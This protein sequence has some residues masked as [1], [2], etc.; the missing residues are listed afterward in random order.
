MKQKIILNLAMSLDGFIAD[1]DGK[2][3]WIVGDGSKA[4]DTAKQF[5]F[6]HFL[7]GIDTIVMGRR[8]YEACDPDMFKNQQ[9]IVATSGEHSDGEKIHFISEDPVAHVRASLGKRVWVFGGGILADAFIKADVIDEY[10]IGIIPVILG[11]GIPL[12]L[13]EHDSRRLTLKAYYMQEG[14][15]ILQYMRRELE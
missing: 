3:D 6:E 11:S 4:L 2:F 8:A 12:F 7:D 1:L 9:L 15:A 5:T 10:I 14:I 13:G